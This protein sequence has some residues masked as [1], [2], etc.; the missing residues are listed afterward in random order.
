MELAEAKK[1]TM[2]SG[3]DEDLDALRAYSLVTATA[4]SNVCEMH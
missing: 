2:I 1:M 3:I 4:K